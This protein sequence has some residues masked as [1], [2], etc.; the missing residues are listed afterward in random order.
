MTQALCPAGHPR[1]HRTKI[2]LQQLGRDL[3]PN[4]D[5]IIVTY[6]HFCTA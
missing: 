1:S 2:H 3:E 4:S 6:L 5:D